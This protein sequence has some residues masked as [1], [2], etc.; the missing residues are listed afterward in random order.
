MRKLKEARLAFWLDRQLGKRR[1]LELYLNV[2]EFGPGI[3]GAEAAA[4]H[5]YGCSAETLDAAA[6]AGLA[7]AIPAPAADNPLTRSPR[8]Q[9]RTRVIAGRMTRATWLWQR[10]AAE[11]IGRLVKTSEAD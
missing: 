7:A 10:L 4:R 6:A 2:V 1:V 8:W 5:Y 11:G 3:Y 9:R